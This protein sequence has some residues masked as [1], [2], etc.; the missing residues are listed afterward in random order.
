MR[1]S[2]QVQVFELAKRRAKAQPA[3][4]RAEVQVRA[5]D[6]STVGAGKLRGVEEACKDKIKVESM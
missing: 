1:K 5:L 2:M 6:L 3:Q 4:V